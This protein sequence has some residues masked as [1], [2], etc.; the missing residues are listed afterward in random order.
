MYDRR[1]TEGVPS[2]AIREISVLKGLNH[3][4]VVQLLDIVV[5]EKKLF[6]VFE[7][8]NM[9]LKE[10]LDASTVKLEE[11][12]VKVIIFSICIF[13]KAQIISIQ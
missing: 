11:D 9:D 7:Y 6:L 4:A 10:F 8:L 3:P 2:T 12:L 1:D 5:V 13:Q